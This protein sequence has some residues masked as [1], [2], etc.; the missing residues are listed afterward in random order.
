MR[1]PEQL[2]PQS[3]RAAFRE[4]FYAL[5]ESVSERWHQLANG[6][7]GYIE[8]EFVGFAVL[9][10]YLKGEPGHIGICFRGP[11]RG[12]P[13]LGA[14]WAVPAEDAGGH[15]PDTMLQALVQRIQEKLAKYANLKADQNLAEL[16]LLVHYDTRAFHLNTP[17][18]APGRK[19]ADIWPRFC[20]S[21]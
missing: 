14:P 1:D 17:F 12:A 3:D 13:A 6:P 19:F 16:N 11:E 8:R 18:G 2:I 7:Q 5:Y 9:A 10:R 21:S 20:G 4:Q 15:D